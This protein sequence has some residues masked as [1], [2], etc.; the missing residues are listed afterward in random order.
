MLA[1]RSSIRLWW[2]TILI[3]VICLASSLHGQDGLRRI[4]VG[5]TMPE[6]ALTDANG[7]TVSYGDKEARVLAIVILQAGQSQRERLVTDIEVLVQK[8]RVEG[9][10]FDCVGVMTGAGTSEYLRSRDPDARG[11]FPIFADP[12]FAFWGKVGVIAAP[13]AVVVGADHKVQWIKAGYGYDFVAGL[14]AQLGKALG[15]TGATDTSGHVETLENN[16]A[17]AR[18]DRHI[19]LARALAK[20]GRLDSAMAELEKV[21]ELDPNAVDIA[22]ELGE[23][24]CRAGRNEA[25]L[26]MANQVKAESN[27]D[28]ARAMLICAWAKRQMGDLDAAGV[29]LTKALELEPDSP[30]I[31]YESG[32]V[33]QARGD[34]E[35][36]LTCYRRALAGIF[37]DSDSAGPSQK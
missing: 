9:D 35:K 27:Q 5:D 15:L 25:A 1:Q 29:L 37:G 12:N 8:L 16:S 28:R 10:A 34:A 17:R 22:L 33:Y 20:K 11:V 21:R 30:H 23:V 3:L 19:Q 14:H 4:H 18:R 32:K 6:F 2:P 26:K 24:L 7:A 36:A 31:L 13:T